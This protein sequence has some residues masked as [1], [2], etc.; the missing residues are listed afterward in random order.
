VRLQLQLLLPSLRLHHSDWAVCT[1]TDLTC[2]SM[3]PQELRDLRARIGDV[4]AFNSAEMTTVELPSAAAQASRLADVLRC[5][6]HLMEQLTGTGQD[7]MEDLQQLMQQI[8]QP[9]PLCER[10]HC[11]LTLYE[12]LLMFSETAAANACSHIA[13]YLF[14]AAQQADNVMNQMAV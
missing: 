6:S 1:V 14:I 2:S 7:S 10:C 12:R 8:P 9:Q 3:N 4:L 13:R 5:T 11:L